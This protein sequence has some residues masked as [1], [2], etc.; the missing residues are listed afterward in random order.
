MCLRRG[1]NVP[2]VD[3]AS[4]GQPSTGIS[5]RGMAKHDW[6][7]RQTHP[8][9]QRYSSKLPLRVPS[10]GHDYRL[11]LMVVLYRRA[12]RTSIGYRIV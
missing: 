5:R 1:R 6:I 9:R 10:E 11:N 2:F 12:N 7:T 4:A 8:P 3:N